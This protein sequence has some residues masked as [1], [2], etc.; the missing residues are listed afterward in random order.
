MCSLVSLGGGL[1]SMETSTI[2]FFDHADESLLL[3][4][5]LALAIFYSDVRHAVMGVT[6]VPDDHTTLTSILRT[7]NKS[8]KGMH[9][10]L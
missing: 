5:T 1:S 9:F 3:A 6:A 4:P 7:L 2:P 8:Q 10:V